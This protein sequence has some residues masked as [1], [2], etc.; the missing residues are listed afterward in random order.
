VLVTVIVD[1]ND[2][3]G[4]ALV[5]RIGENGHSCM[6]QSSATEPVRYGRT[7]LYG[8][9]LVVKVYCFRKFYY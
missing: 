9:L 4:D 6:I 8:E 1:G 5:W 3:N 7:Y 2:G